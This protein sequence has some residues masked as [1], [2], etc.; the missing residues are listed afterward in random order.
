MTCRTMNFGSL[1]PVDLVW[2]F[3]T[4]WTFS[5]HARARDPRSMHSVIYI[6]Y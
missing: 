6:L 3:S 1:E 5:V 4:L 2:D